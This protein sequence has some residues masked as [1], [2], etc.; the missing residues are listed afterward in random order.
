M[1]G[2]ATKTMAAET[3]A[4]ADGTGT[5]NTPPD[6]ASSAK[7][8][9]RTRKISNGLRRPPVP[10]AVAGENGNGGATGPRPKTAGRRPEPGKLVR[11]ASNLDKDRVEKAMRKTSQVERSRKISVERRTIARQPSNLHERLL[12]SRASGELCRPTLERRQSSMIEKL[13]ERSST[14]TSS[15]DGRNSS[16]GLEKRSSW[17]DADKK[18]GPVYRVMSGRLESIPPLSSKIVR[19]FTSSTF[20]GKSGSCICGVFSVF[21]Q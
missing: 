13:L 9:V 11:Q 1:E 18:E 8:T 12:A 5:N 2:D 20:T 16:S 15:D 6:S 3:A 7:K 4:V 14:P 10:T 17:M 19:V 21:F